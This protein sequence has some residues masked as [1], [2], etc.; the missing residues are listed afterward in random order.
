MTELQAIVMAKYDDI[1]TSFIKNN[2]PD[3]VPNVMSG[4]TVDKLYKHFYLIKG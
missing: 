1:F 3:L 4:K 2:N